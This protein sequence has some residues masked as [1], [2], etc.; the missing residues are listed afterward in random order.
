MYDPAGSNAEHSKWI[1]IYNNGDDYELSTTTSGDLYKI[2]NFYVCDELSKATGL[3]TKHYIYSDS[4]KPVFKNKEYLIIAQ[5]TDKFMAD[6]SDLKKPLKSALSIDGSGDAFVKICFQDDEHCIDAVQ[7]G[8]YD[9]A[10]K[11]GYS[12]EKTNLDENNS[13]K[14]LQRSY[15]KNGTPAMKKS[16]RINYP[17]GIIIN[18]LFPHPDTG[19]EEF[20]ELYNSM[21][22]KM[23]LDDWL[24]VDRADKTCKLDGKHI[25]SEDFLLIEKNNDGCEIALN[26][27]GEETVRLLD[28]NGD[29]VYEAEYATTKENLSYSYDGKNWR[30][31]KF[32][33]PGEENKFEKI[34]K[35]E[36][37][38][39]EDI[40]VNVYAHFEIGGLS[41]KAKV[42]WNFGDGHKSYV[43]KT[44]HKY[45]ET[46]KYKASVKYSEGSEDVVKDFEIEVGKIPHPEV[47][48]VSINANPVGSDTKNEYLVPQK[49]NYRVYY[50]EC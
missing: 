3:C 13:E 41:K 1:E 37:D 34:P 42:I 28:P 26:D 22:N 31:S 12:L 10:E 16:E 49:H 47:K 32:L 50:S 29:V 40:Y 8:S 25:D 11:E 35:G 48:I 38:I 27:T 24:I 23:L 7:Y 45:S 20:I 18:E 33:T 46:G 43:Q 44:K 5:N 4:E 15:Q 17:N 19:A 9:I 2:S 30:W 21:K 14:N 6:Y 39:D 36:L